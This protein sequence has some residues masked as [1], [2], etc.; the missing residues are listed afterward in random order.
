[1]RTNDPPIVNINM[2]G[3]MAW[4]EDM[5]SAKIG[6]FEAG[7]THN[8]GYSVY[9][10]GTPHVHIHLTSTASAALNSFEA[11]PTG[12]YLLMR[13]AWEARVGSDW[14]PDLVSGRCCFFL[15]G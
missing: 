7:S 1:M 12:L 3:M 9:T 10:G 14:K 8:N 4:A 2:D 11:G 13:V 6:R 5:R 15:G